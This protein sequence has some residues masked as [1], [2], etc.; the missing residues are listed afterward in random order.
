MT[1]ISPFWSRTAAA[2]GRMRRRARRAGELAHDLLEE[3]LRT[4]DAVTFT[5]RTTG[6]DPEHPLFASI[7]DA[8]QTRQEH[9]GVG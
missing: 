4:D 8:V 7:R 6:L 9:I 3:L 5:T 1:A 2:S